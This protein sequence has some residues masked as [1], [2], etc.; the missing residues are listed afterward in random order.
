MTDIFEAIGC[1][2]IESIPTTTD[3]LDHINFLAGN[4]CGKFFKADKLLLENISKNKVIYLA[5]DVTKIVEVIRTHIKSL[6][7]YVIKELSSNYEGY[8]LVST[9][10][11]PI[12]VHGVGVYFNNFFNGKNYFDLITAEH[13]FQ[14]LSESNKESSAYRKGI[15]LTEVKKEEDEVEFN[16]LRCSTN[17]Q[18]PTDN[19]RSTDI[20]IIEKLNNLFSDDKYAKLNHV[21]AQVYTNIIDSNNKEKKAKIKDHSDKTK[22]MLKN[23]LMAF[24]TFYKSHDGV[25]LNNPATLTRLR[26]RLKPPHEKYDLNEKFEV[27]L[28][29]GSVL[30]I[31]LLTNRLYTH[32]IVP[33]FLP[34]N[35]IPTRLG[36]VVRSSKTKAVFKDGQTFIVEDNGDLTELR[37]PTGDDAKK[38]KDLY[39]E[40]NMTDN[41]V[42][43]GKIYFS[44]NE[45]DYKEPIQ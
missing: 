5:G 38:L 26:F 29:P 21:L 17:L 34:I 39:Y 3:T 44:L 28:H 7:I 15:Y 31:P 11:T 20:E 1:I 18:G 22:D 42:D 30:I 36:Y 4:F 37:K 43:Y 14:V 6:K 12:N 27:I 8:D 45:G 2:D 16:L 24:C 25:D 13:E 35:K 33:S 19:F 41:E 23:A 9:K 40:E 10:D 32:E